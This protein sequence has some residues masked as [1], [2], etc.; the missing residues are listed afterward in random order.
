MTNPPK[1]WYAVPVRVPDARVATRRLEPE[2]GPLLQELFDGL[3]DFGTPF[4]EPGAADAVSTYLAL[5]E[6][7][8]Y[9]D[10]VLVGVWDADRLVGAIDWIVDYPERRT[11]A[12]GLLLLADERRGHGVGR[13]LVR[14]LEDEARG[15]SA[16]RLRFAVREAN[17]AGHDFLT[18]IGYAAPDDR[19]E[20]GAILLTK[21]LTG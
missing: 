15:E 2:D 1:D 19:L 18:G 13:A 3:A 6:G 14:W 12:V 20:D 8:G 21:N 17:V 10:K 5:P 9:D 16:E 7:K 4:G 11:W